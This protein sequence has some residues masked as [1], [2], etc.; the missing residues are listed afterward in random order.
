VVLGQPGIS[1]ARTATLE[2]VGRKPTSRIA[3]REG[4]LSACERGSLVL[5]SCHTTFHPSTSLL[6]AQLTTTDT[7]HAAH[8]KSAPSRRP[9]PIR[10]TTQY[11]VFDT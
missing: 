8:G 11:H 6:S 5:G 2:D 1:T 3:F 10:A 4:G 9:R 7:I